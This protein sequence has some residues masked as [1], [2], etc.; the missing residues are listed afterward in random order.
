LSYHFCT[1]NF[2]TDGQSIEGGYIQEIALTFAKAAYVKYML[3]LVLRQS[4][5]GLISSWLNVLGVQVAFL[6]F[7]HGQQHHIACTA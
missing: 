5:A 2:E 3:I 1:R 6:S 4:S 7:G